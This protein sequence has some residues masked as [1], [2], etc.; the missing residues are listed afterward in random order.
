MLWNS[1]V[2]RGR[3]E[4]TGC[5]IE[6]STCLLFVSEI[7]SRTHLQ[8]VEMCLFWRF[9]SWE[10]WKGDVLM[11]TLLCTPCHLT[12]MLDVCSP[13]A[14]GHSTKPNTQVLTQ[15]MERHGPLSHDLELY[16]GNRKKNSRRP[17]R[18]ANRLNLSMKHVEENSE[19]SLC[20]IMARPVLLVSTPA[21]VPG[22]CLG[23]DNR[24]G[25]M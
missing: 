15:H 24:W 25:E 4:V 16:P 22:N 19:E 11:L 9:T 3:L 1:L 23:L 12:C 17:T 18:R 10:V 13:A 7:L 6:R 21:N 2:V 20:R 8:T 14:T 5:S